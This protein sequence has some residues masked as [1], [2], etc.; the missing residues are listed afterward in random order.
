PRCADSGIRRG[1]GAGCGR[2]GAERKP[3]RRRGLRWV[4]RQNW[5]LAF[6]SSRTRGGVAL[7][8]D[9]QAIR[10]G[11]LRQ[12]AAGIVDGSTGRSPM[13]TS[14]RQ[15][16]VA[17]DEIRQFYDG[18]YYSGDA[19]ADRLPWHMRKVAARL[20]RLRGL[21]VLDIACGT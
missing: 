4:G 11:R 14:D 19:A 16:E 2:R 13:T 10:M 15:G 18:T 21:H 7:H 9:G 6:T 8:G 5:L 12:T 17:H 1:G 20:G 3:C